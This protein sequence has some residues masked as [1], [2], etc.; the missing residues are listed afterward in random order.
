M[1]DGERRSE[2]RKQVYLVGNGEKV[3]RSVSFR[4]SRGAVDLRVLYSSYGAGWAE[5]TS[6]IRDK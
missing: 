3:V 6:L 5:P 4:R 2:D 1:T